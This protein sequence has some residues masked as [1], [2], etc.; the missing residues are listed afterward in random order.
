M[1]AQMLMIVTIHSSNS[2]SHI[3]LI[4]IVKESQAEISWSKKK[5]LRKICCTIWW[6]SCVNFVNHQNKTE[7]EKTEVPTSFDELRSILGFKHKIHPSII[8]SMELGLKSSSPLREM[9]ADNIDITTIRP[10][11]STA[12]D[13]NDTIPCLI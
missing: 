11:Y 3:P 9:F 8:D 7:S 12:T 4:K 10:S 1:F 6:Q 5:R 2:E 13:E